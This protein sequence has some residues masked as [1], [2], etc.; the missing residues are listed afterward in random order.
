MKPSIRRSS[1][2]HF[3]NAKDFGLSVVKQKSDYNFLTISV[4]GEY[5]TII[6]NRHEA[7]NVLRKFKKALAKSRVES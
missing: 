5:T 6:V 4:V 7:A 2:L 1:H 3:Y